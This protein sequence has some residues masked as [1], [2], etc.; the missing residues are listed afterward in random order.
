M[1]RNL[2][3]QYEIVKD[4][5]I[6][7]NDLFY[8]SI[9]IIS[10]KINFLEEIYKTGANLTFSDEFKDQAYKERDYLC[11]LS[12]KIYSLARELGINK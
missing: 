4:L 1:K 6:D 3:K 8:K 9:S 12:S 11:K 10:K 5:I 2:Q 7:Q